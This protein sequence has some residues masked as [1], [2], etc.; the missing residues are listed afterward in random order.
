MKTPLNSLYTPYGAFEL[1]ATYQRNLLMGTLTVTL[2]VGLVLLGA[3]M[4]P[5]DAIELVPPT[6]EPLDT[7]SVVITPPPTIIRSGGGTGVPALPVDVVP[8]AIPTPVPDEDYPDEEGPVIASQ[9]ELATLGLPIGEGG[10]GPGTDGLRGGVID[11]NVGQWPSPDSMVFADVMPTLIKQYQGDYPRVARELGLT[12]NVTVRVLLDREGKVV[13]SE[14]VRSS[15]IDALDEA[16]VAWAKKCI[17]SP[18]IQGNQPIPI[19][20]YFTYEFVLDR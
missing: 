18:A 17:F 13:K 16:A 14:L 20:V 9:S 11:T 5:T 8:N 15:E 6:P 7:V 1:K 2:A 10:M 12:G 4:W 3:A 19:W